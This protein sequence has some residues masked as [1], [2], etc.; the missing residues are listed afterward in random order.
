MGEAPQ[1]E[2]VSVC[3]DHPPHFTEKRTMAQSPLPVLD[4]GWSPHG[5]RLRLEGNLVLEMADEATL[6]GSNPR[7]KRASQ[8]DALI[9]DDDG[10]P[11]IS[12]SK[13]HPQRGRGLDEEQRDGH[14]NLIGQAWHSPD[15][16]RRKLPDPSAMCPI[17]RARRHTTTRAS[18]SRRQRSARGRASMRRASWDQLRARWQ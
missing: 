18:T 15:S 17:C 4:E 1:E 2:G 6:S 12:H 7:R 10:V 8:G 13:A 9:F 11:G 5:K 14:G 3:G 16:R